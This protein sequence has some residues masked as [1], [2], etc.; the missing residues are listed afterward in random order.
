MKKGIIIIIAALLVLAFAACSPAGTA[1]PVQN[2][3]RADDGSIRGIVTAVST[4]SIEIAKTEGG[5]RQGRSAVGFTGPKPE[6]A[7]AD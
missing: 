2:G 6:P 4:G 3:Q 1:N 5:N 7:A